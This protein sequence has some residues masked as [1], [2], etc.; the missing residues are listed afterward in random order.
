M[1][2]PR[3]IILSTTIILGLSLDALAQ[4]TSGVPNSF[5]H[6]SPGQPK[7]NFSPEWQ[8]YFK[9][10]DKLPNIT[11]TL[12]CNFA[13]NIPNGALTAP[14]DANNTDPWIIWLQ[15]G[16]GSSGMVALTTEPNN[17][18]FIN[19]FSWNNLADTIWV[20]QP[21]GTGFSTSDST[22]YVSD[23]DQTGE[24]FIGFLSNLAKVFPSLA[25]RPLFL[26]G[27]SYAGMY[28]PY[29]TKHIFRNSNPPVNLSKIA[30]RDGSLGSQATIR[31][32]PILNVIETYPAVIGYNQQVFEFF[33]EQTH[34]CGF[35]LNL[36][37]LQSS[38]FPTLDLIRPTQNLVLSQSLLDP[39]EDRARTL[40][41]TA[42][43]RFT[44]LHGRDAL[45]KRSDFHERREAEH[46]TVDPFYGCF[47]LDELVDYAVNFTFPWTNSEFDV[48]D[49]PDATSPE[50]FKN[51]S[52]FFN[53]DRTRAA[54][55]SPTSKDWIRNFNYPF[56]SVHNRSRG[57]QYGDPSVEPV[58]FL[59]DLATNASAHNVSIIFY[60]GNDDALVQHRGM[61]ERNLT[62]L[63]FDGAGHLIPL[64]NPAQALVF[65]REFVLRS[66]S[67]GTVSGNSVVGGE[68]TTL[69]NDFLPGGEEIFFGSSAT[70]GTSTIPAATRS[71]W[72]SFIR[73]TTATGLPSDSKTNSASQ[74]G[75]S[76][77]ASM[78]AFVSAGLK[79]DAFASLLRVHLTSSL[80]SKFPHAE[81]HQELAD[82]AMNCH[83]DI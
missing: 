72:A 50:P 29:I 2:T 11:G 7:G 53:D 57:N 65:L 4:G 17:S 60:S 10:T 75:G 42:S 77:M 51:A 64:W 22:G 52:T 13:G 59:S 34:L 26:T 40:R 45:S 46:Q 74:R 54:L 44:E 62:Y 33:R 8:N 56:G 41:E 37:Y 31:H 18:W 5:P 68:N 21:I 79:T 76:V 73:G 23:E 78:L 66:N 32:L 80:P 71:A 16:P 15:G 39:T 30:I 20:D 27:E 49:V 6:A 14:A 82:H 61:E 55:H 70:V 3:H 12:P 58:A 63:L 19:E 81:G 1:H 24:D 25:T 9:V 47:L 67:N 36:T 48:Y 35:D 28:I 38:H 83:V 69:P 43:A